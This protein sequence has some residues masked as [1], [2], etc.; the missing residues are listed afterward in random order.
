M[1]SNELVA[2]TQTT[3]FSNPEL[4]KATEEIRNLAVMVS[5]KMNTAK[6]DIARIIATVDNNKAYEKDG[7]E[8]VVDFGMQVFGW[9]KSTAQMYNQVGHYI[10]AGNPLNDKNGH[11]FNFTQLRAMAGVKNAKEL[12][13]AVEDGA[14]T[15]D[16]SEDECIEIRNAI[17]PQRKTAERKEKEFSIFEY[18][19][20]EPVYVGT[21]G[22]FFADH[23]EPHYAYTKD[24][25]KFYVYLTAEGAKVYYHSTGKVVATVEA[26]PV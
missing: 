4:N 16:M 6:I 26:T 24:N 12:E 2:K 17:N 7:F 15:A 3:A 11:P 21:P 14:F 10:V 18:G 19:V 13:K 5:M 25:Y 1:K 20:S 9:G 8:S 23:G 22:N